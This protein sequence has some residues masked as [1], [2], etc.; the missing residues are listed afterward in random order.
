M[1]Q[2]NERW[3]DAFNLDKV[4]LRLQKSDNSKRTDIKRTLISFRRQ[5]TFGYRLEK[6]ESY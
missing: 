5:D 4:Q 1:Q 3:A 2:N 6:K